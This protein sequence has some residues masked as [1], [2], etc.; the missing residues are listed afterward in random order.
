[1]KSFYVSAVLAVVVVA[2]SPFALAQYVYATPLLVASGD[3]G[4]IVRVLNASSL[5]A[6][7]H[8]EL[9]DDE[10]KTLQE[11]EMGIAP[12]SVGTLNDYLGTMPALGSVLITANRPLSTIVIVYQS[13]KIVSCV[14]MTEVS[15]PATARVCREGR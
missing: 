9:K 3:A 2:L 14:P 1:M 5:P 13:G 8:C 15:R 11:S 6:A 10:G 7:V 4:S 12:W